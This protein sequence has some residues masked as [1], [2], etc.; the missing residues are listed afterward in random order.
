MTG[1]LILENGGW[2]R[3]LPAAAATAVLALL[4]VW[5]AVKLMVRRGVHGLMLQISTAVLALVLWWVLYPVVSPLFS[6]ERENGRV[7]WTLTGDSLTIGEDVIP[8]GTVKAVHC[9]ANRSALGTA[10]GG[11]TVNIETNGKNR[12]LRSLRSGQEAETSDRLLR[13]LV[14]AMGYGARLPQKES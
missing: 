5:P 3:R 4:V 12:V 14:E 6:R 9:W 8:L 11:L 13:E 2:K 1:E 7:R 10:D